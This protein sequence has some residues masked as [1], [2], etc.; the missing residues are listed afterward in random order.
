MLKSDWRIDAAVWSGDEL[1]GTASRWCGLRTRCAP[2]RRCEHAFRDPR[3]RCI[4]RTG[5]RRDRLDYVRALSEVIRAYVPRRYVT[6]GT[7]SFGR[8]DTRQSLEFFEVDRVAIVLAALKS[9]VDEGVND[10]SLLKRSAYLAP[11]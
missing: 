6:L 3:T 7:D 8:S 10:R 2:R 9:L 4:A 5:D 1:Y 11:A